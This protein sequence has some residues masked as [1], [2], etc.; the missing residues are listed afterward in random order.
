MKVKKL[1][2]IKGLRIKKKKKNGATIKEK[3]LKR[4]VKLKKTKFILTF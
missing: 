2:E 1:D 4:Q 3:S